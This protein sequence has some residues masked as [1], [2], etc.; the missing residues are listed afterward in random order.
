M[1]IP[2]FDIVVPKEY[3]VQVNGVP[4]KRTTWNRVGT[5]WPSKSGESLSFELHLFP[6]LRYV[7]QTKEKNQ[8]PAVTHE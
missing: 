2:F 1:S 5:A 4:Q 6:G 7:I 3:E 8:G